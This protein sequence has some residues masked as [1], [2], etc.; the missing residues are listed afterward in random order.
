MPG[1][2]WKSRYGNLHLLSR[3]K[4]YRSSM[5]VVIMIVVVIMTVIPTVPSVAVPPIP[6]ASLLFLVQLAVV[7]ILVV[8]VGSIP[9][10][11]VGIFVRTPIV[12]VV[13][14][15]IMGSV[16]ASVFGAANTRKR[17]SHGGYKQNGAQVSFAMTHFVAPP[18]RGLRRSFESGLAHRIILKD[19]I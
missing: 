7:P 1:K 16:V 4:P 11:V 5:L 17:Q 19:W 18:R 12:I 14:I 2:Q 13:V 10:M 15:G 8:V 3:T 6:I 9:L